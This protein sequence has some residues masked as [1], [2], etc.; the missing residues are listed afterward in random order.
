MHL[1]NT[2]HNAKWGSKTNLKSLRVNTLYTQEV[3]VANATFRVS[4][5]FQGNNIN[6]TDLYLHV[7]ELTKAL[8]TDCDIRILLLV[9]LALL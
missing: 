2:M 7:T 9:S 5:P 4:E 6:Y 8:S 1:A 3:N